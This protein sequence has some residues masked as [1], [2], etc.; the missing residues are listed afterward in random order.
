[1][2]ELN[3]ENLFKISREYRK[4]FLK[5]GILY[6]ENKNLKR[7]DPNAFEGLSNLRYLHLQNNSITNLEGISFG[8][9]K[10]LQDLFLYGNK[11]K[12]IDSN[13]FKGL[14]FL[15]R[16][17]LD[18]NEI[19]EI[20]DYAFETLSSLRDLLLSNNKL[21][22]IH[23]NT[24][25]ISY[26][27]LQNLHLD[28]NEIEEI[29][30]KAFESL[31]KLMFLRLNKNRL[32]TIDW[33]FFEPLK[34]VKVV[35]FFNNNFKELSLYTELEECFYWAGCFYYNKSELEVFGSISNRNA[36]LDQFS[37]STYR[38]QSPKLLIVDYYDDLI[39]DIDIYTEEQ[40]AKYSQ[41][42]LLPIESNP[43][44]PSSVEIEGLKD[45]Y[46]IEY[47]NESEI[48][49]TPGWT[50]IIDYLNLVRSKAIEEIN[51][52]KEE[53]LER[54]ELN[55]S[56]YKYDR[57]NMSDENLEEMKRELFK[58]KFCFLIRFEKFESE[59]TKFELVTVVTDFYLD[60][61]ERHLIK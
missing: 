1:M 10:H 44:Y 24:F 42:D 39:R 12:R 46:K 19:E 6:L 2:T 60:H 36:F 35:Q 27:Q 31:S 29:D 52:A 53:N 15:R 11:L 17:G 55:K 50:K 26:N 57:N 54:Y 23:S 3:R 9:L 13:I 5:Y 22:R 38:F 32:K 21:K 16:L 33:R 61:N 49:V 28:H 47:K 48:N 14:T 34:S 45:P 18:Y 30:P 51:K 59:S 25:L 40:L 20:D 43:E 7:I 41:D 37:K 4:Y 58:E 56:K 8:Y